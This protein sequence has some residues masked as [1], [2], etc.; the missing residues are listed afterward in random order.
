MFW[1]VVL[2]IWRNFSAFYAIRIGLHITHIIV[3]IPRDAIFIYE[4][5]QLTYIFLLFQIL[6]SCLKSKICLLIFF[7]GY[8]S[9]GWPQLCLICLF[10]NYLAGCFLILVFHL[11]SDFHFLKMELMRRALRYFNSNLYG[12][13]ICIQQPLYSSTQ[14]NLIHK[15]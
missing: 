8:L 3:T 12:K 11:L 15:K 9:F 6:I 7:V 14:Y 10:F 4:R 2:Y 1:M 5:R 13:L